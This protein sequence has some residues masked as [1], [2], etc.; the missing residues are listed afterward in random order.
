[1]AIIGIVLGMRW[2]VT[3]GTASLEILRHRRIAMTVP[4]ITEQ[5]GEDVVV[6]KAG[7]RSSISTEAQ[8]RLRVVVGPPS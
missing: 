8:Q 4:P 3:Q 5:P 1:M 7:F 2:L 6:T